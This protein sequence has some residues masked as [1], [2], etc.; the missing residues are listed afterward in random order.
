MW[1][2]LENER[3]QTTWA[4]VLR[5]AL[6]AAALFALCNLVY[7]AVYPTAWLGRLSLYGAVYPARERL[8]YAGDD[9]TRAYNVSV[10]N[11]NAMFASHTIARRKAAD[12]FRVLL[13]GDSATWGWFLEP[14]ETYAAGIN[15]ANATLADGRRVVAYNLGYPVLSVTK[16][17]VLLD[18]ARRYE[19][20][21]V[22][23]LVTAQSLRDVDERGNPVQTGDP[24]SAW[25]FDR[26]R[27][28]VPAV[29]PPSWWA[30]T[31]VGQRRELASL[32]RLQV[33]GGVWG[34]TGID[35]AI[36]DEFALRRSDLSA[37][38]AWAGFD[39]PTDL[40][41][42]DLALDVLGRGVRLMGDVPVVV[43]N[44]PVFISNGANSTIRYNSFYPRWAYDAYRDL[45]AGLAA[46]QNW[47]YY[48][49]WDVLPPDQFTDTPVHVTAVAAARLS[50]MLTEVIVEEAS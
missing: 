27:L 19:P 28:G 26:E 47:P 41:R 40:T 49:W 3:E 18:Y 31:V 42:D 21:M 36:P 5:V 8:P 16:D 33:Y 1:G 10:D 25:A 29:A 32:L 45:L 50:A 35:H 22:V 4:F 44:E 39:G 6:K 11:L 30:R 38:A 46:E 43:V 20:D 14:D 23:W 13:V 37:S 7:A 48:D 17:L 24:V 34:A 2:W 12:E 15:A 9:S